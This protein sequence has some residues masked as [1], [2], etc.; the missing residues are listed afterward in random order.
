MSKVDKL[1]KLNFFNPN[2]LVENV[3]I[4]SILTLFLSMYGPRLHPKLPQSLKKLFD[5]AVFRGSVLFLI[6]YMAKRDFAGA[7]TVALIFMI[8]MNIINTSKVLERF[9]NHSLYQRVSMPIKGGPVANCSVYK[10][11]DEQK[12]GTKFY[13]LNDNNDLKT[14]RGGNYVGNEMSGEL[15]LD[16]FN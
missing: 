15:N 9:D 10:H 2:I 11:S 14:L 1:P 8:T 16:R 13:P 6:A 12:L 7:L 4:F 3:F 5:S